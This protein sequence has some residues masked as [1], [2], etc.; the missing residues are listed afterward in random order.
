MSWAVIALRKIQPDVRSEPGGKHGA[1]DPK[2][3]SYTSDFWGFSN[4]KGEPNDRRP[5]LC[6]ELHLTRLL[7]RA[8]SEGID[9]T[10]NKTKIVTYIFLFLC[11]LLFMKS[12]TQDL[13]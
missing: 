6:S 13:K 4:K 7:V 5:V 12:P 2:G 3:F 11:H 9:G 8:Y 10:L 1:A